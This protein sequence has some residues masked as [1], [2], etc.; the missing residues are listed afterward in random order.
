DYYCAVWP[1]NTWVF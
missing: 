1:I